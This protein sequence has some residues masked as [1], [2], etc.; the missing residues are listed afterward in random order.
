MAKNDCSRKESLIHSYLLAIES[1]WGCRSFMLLVFLFLLPANSISSISIH[2]PL[3]STN[4]TA[5]KNHP[6]LFYDQSDQKQMQKRIT[7]VPWSGWWNI[8]RDSSV[9]STP[10]FVWWMT[11]DLV[12]A[13]RSRLDLLRTP[14]WRE[15]THGYLETSSHSLSDFVVAYDILASWRGLSKTDHKTIRKKIYKE[16]EYYYT[17]LSGELT[18]GANYGNQ[19]ILAASVLGL[20]ALTLNDGHPD[21]KGTDTRIYDKWLE[22]AVFEIFR[23][24]NFWF[25]RPGGRFVE[26][27]DYS[28]YLGIQFIPFLIAYNRVKE[29]NFLKSE[30]LVTWLEF[31]AYQVANDGAVVPWGTAPVGTGLS[32]FGLLNNTAY[33]GNRFPL[34]RTVFNLVPTP[35]FQP[36]LKHIAIALYDVPSNVGDAPPASRA[37]PESQAVTMRNSWDRDAVTIW[38]AGKEGDWP[39][40]HLHNSYSHADAGHFVM[41]AWGEFLVSDSG[42]DHWRTL[43]S[44]GGSDYAG[45]DFHNVIL[46]DGKGPEKDTKGILSNISLQKKSVKHATITTKYQGCT[47]RRTL[48]LIR[49]RYVVVVDNIVANHAHVFSWRLH[50]AGIDYPKVV[51]TGRSIEWPGTRFN[52]ER[53]TRGET[54]LETVFPPNMKLSVSPGRWMPLWTQSEKKNHIAIADWKGASASHLF[55]LL[56]S[57]K[58]DKLSWRSPNNSSGMVVQGLRWRDSIIVRDGSLQVESSDGRVEFSANI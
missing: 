5:P 14:I 56:P 53:L 16:A 31:M 47:I 58:S 35:F 22:R 57:K 36:Y 28:R 32:L 7:K 40:K 12:S 8:L 55:L 17:V 43:N 42:Y 15:P 52:S 33:G 24:E 19:R 1:L 49:G 6:F 20:A 3:K 39:I 4:A 50:S 54:A 45:P 46:I 29:V 38:F 10:A 9:L 44:P 25:F 51:F 13:K 23:E 37:F 21:P 30:R 26:G 34:F 18:G 2:K 27:V 41:S 11:G 48:F